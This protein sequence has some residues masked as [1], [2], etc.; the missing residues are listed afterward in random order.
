M[1]I[2]ITH[3]RFTVDEYHRMAEIGILG[4]DERVE[5]IDGEIVDMTPI[6][7]RHMACLDRLNRLFVSGLGER[8]I[9]RVGGAIR[10][11]Q[12]SEPQPDLVL[13]RP[14]ADFYAASYAGPGD[15]LLVIEV[16]DSS[17]RYDRQV[18]VPLYARPGV[19]EVWLVDLTRINVTVYHE[20]TP[21]RYAQEIVATGEDALSPLAFP[22][23][24]LTA[25]RILG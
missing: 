19:P 21:D 8:A 12:H 1:A 16:A 23:F 13:L 22:D 4:E 20:P 9:V 3:H 5:L 7:P 2:A 17:E 25:A 6:G 15:T 10:L 14:R 18:K 11:Q 24:V